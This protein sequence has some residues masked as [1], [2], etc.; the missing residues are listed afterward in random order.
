VL[1]GVDVHRRAAQEADQ[2]EASFFRPVRRRARTARIPRRAAGYLGEQGPRTPRTMVATGCSQR[3]GSRTV[4]IDRA[5]SG[6]AYPHGAIQASVAA[7]PRVAGGG[8]CH[9]GRAAR[10]LLR[11]HGQQSGEQPADQR[12]HGHLGRTPRIHPQRHLPV[13]RAGTAATDQ[14]RED[15][16]RLLCQACAVARLDLGDTCD[17]AAAAYSAR[18]W[19]DLRRLTADLPLPS[20]LAGPGTSSDTRSAAGPR[21]RRRPSR[22]LVVAV[23]LTRWRG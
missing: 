15:A 10:R 1:S 9:R 22:R 8:V 7:D 21:L 16:V 13:H 19:G 4:L 6:T 23:L 3:R 12:Q 18:T 17:R 20:A 2:R 14:D 11:Q 5:C